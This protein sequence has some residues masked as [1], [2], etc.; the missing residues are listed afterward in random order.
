MKQLKFWYAVNGTG[1]GVVFISKPIRNEH[2]R[3]WVGDIS[4]CV[5]RF[6]DWLETESMIGFVLPNISWNDDCV[7]ININVDANFD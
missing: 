4:I 2:R 3:I 5:T 1:Q 7:E 6:I